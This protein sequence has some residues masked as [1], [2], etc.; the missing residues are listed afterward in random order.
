MNGLD[1]SVSTTGASATIKASVKKFADGGFPVTGEMFVARE[2]GPELVG[3]IGNKT[4]VANNDQIIAGIASGVEDANKEVISA[5]FAVGAQII[6]AI[7]ESGDTYMDGEKVTGA[8]SAI[9]MRQNR[10]YGTT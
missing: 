1:L 10:M 3:R 6:A 2:A 8:V 4:A 9:Q 5:A 7:R